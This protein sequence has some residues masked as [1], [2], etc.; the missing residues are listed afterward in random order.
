MGISRKPAT[1]LPALPKPYTTAWPVSRLILSNIA[2]RC[3]GM[4]A[5]WLPRGPV[6]RAPI[7]ILEVDVDRLD[8]LEGF[9]VLRVDLVPPVH[10]AA[11]DALHPEVAVRP[12]LRLVH[13]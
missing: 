12:H 6:P 3:S 9:G 5:G 2:V 1:R 10:R 7:P 8:H 4:R 11:A 13:R